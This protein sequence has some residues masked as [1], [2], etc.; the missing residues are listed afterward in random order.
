MTT[1]AER[2]IAERT[3]LGLDQSAAA[4]LLG[5]SRGAY[6]ALE[7]ATQNPRTD[8]LEKLVKLGM[9]IEVLCPELCDGLARTQA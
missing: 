8:T 2:V 3:H 1:F 6:R 4:R 9:R 7:G 5:M